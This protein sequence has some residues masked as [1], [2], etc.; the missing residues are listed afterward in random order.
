MATLEDIL[1][2]FKIH[3]GQFFG[4]YKYKN[5][6]W[7]LDGQKLGYGDLRLSDILYIQTQL[8]DGEEFVGWNEH[9]FSEFRQTKTP[10]IRIRQDSVKYREDIVAEEGR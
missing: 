9:H 7:E 3:D 8:N 5:L 6:W 10:M 4:D 2:R 1:A